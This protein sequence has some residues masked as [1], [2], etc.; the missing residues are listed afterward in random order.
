MQIA[1]SNLT[2]MYG[3]CAEDARKMRGFALQIPSSEI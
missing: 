1:N 2:M 3:T